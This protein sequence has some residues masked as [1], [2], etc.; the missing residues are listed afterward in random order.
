MCWHWWATRPWGDWATWAGAIGTVLAFLVAFSQLK[1]ES[2]ARTKEI[3]ER[4]TR[5]NQDQATKV[6]AWMGSVHFEG[7][8]PQQGSSK[9]VPQGDVPQGDVP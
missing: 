8:D 4:N 6:T 2:A 7:E 1:K 5:E 3:T 9:D